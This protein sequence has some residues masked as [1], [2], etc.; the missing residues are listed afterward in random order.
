M[1]SGPRGPRP[2]P[3]RRGGGDEIGWATMMISTYT[4][5]NSRGSGN[6]HINGIISRDG[7]GVGE[8]STMRRRLRPIIN[9][10]KVT[11]NSL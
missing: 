9:I 2:K 6:W 1:P 8:E 5:D 4:V 3:G 11:I 7:G 10:S